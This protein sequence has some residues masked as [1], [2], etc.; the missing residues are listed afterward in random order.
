MP[1]TIPLTKGQFA[2]VD[3]DDF[4][5]LNQY[6]WFYS[7]N[8]YARRSEIVNGKRRFF[9]MHRVIMGIHASRGQL[10]DHIDGNRLNNTRTNLR[11]VTP[12]QNNWNRSR[13]QR[14]SSPYKGVSQHPRGWQVRIRFYGK[15]VHL[16][17]YDDLE[18][19]ARAYDAAAHSLFG[20]HA[21]LN[22]PDGQ[23]DPFLLSVLQEKLKPLRG[24][25]PQP[26]R[27][28]RRF[29]PRI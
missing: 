5:I 27:P 11:F 26:S 12:N 15:R 14:G 25:G 17:Y 29:A 7:S 24:L 18:E 22:F 28:V 20:Q 6:R 13:N 21:K 10:V 4:A 8:G 2:L 19:A 16:G 1:Q 23:V 3:H 9:Y